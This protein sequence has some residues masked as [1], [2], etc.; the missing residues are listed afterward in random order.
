MVADIG[1]R[2][3][4]AGR[5]LTR[6][7]GIEPVYPYTNGALRGN[8][9]VKDEAIARV[10]PQLHQG[11]AVGERGAGPIVGRQ[12]HQTQERQTPNHPNGGVEA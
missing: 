6:R 1:R 2:R 10:R 11:V 3:G 7:L 8:L 4:V 5:R 12:Q 9:M